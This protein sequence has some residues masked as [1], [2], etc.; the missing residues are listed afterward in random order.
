[1]GVVEE[2]AT[3]MTTVEVVVE[4]TAMTAEG[5]ATEM[6]TAGVVAE[7]AGT[8]MT[9]AAHAR[10]LAVALTPLLRAAELAD[11][12]QVQARAPNFPEH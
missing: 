1:M 3:A 7:E 12:V 4:G 10:P 2:V 8:A 11:E 5:G 9:D 6:T